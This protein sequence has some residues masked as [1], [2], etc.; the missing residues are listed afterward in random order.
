[1][2]KR[3]LLSLA[4]LLEKLP[5]KRFNFHQWVSH[6]WDGVTPLT[7][8]RCDIAACAGGWATTIP[9]LR[10]AGLALNESG[11]IVLRGGGKACIAIGLRALMV[12]F[13]ISYHDALG[14]FFP[15][16]VLPGFATPKQVAKYIR[17]FVA[18]DAS[19]R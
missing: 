6:D 16:C 2:K 19:W 10:R 13:A 1:M 7:H 17:R 11:E 15:D 9:S 14:I 3:R 18:G 8:K 12:V 4:N 5:R